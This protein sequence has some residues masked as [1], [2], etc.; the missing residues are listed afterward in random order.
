MSAAEVENFATEYW[1]DVEIDEL[2]LKVNIQSTS[3]PTTFPS[4]TMS[5]SHTTPTLALIVTT[6]TAA[7]IYATNSTKYFSMKL[8]DKGGILNFLDVI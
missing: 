3:L 7:D 8:D 4:T 2:E 6:I 1:F 5:I